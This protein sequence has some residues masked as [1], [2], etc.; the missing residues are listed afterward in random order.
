MARPD[1]QEELFMTVVDEI[2]LLHERL[3]TVF[4]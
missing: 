1:P 4:K 3:S 2:T